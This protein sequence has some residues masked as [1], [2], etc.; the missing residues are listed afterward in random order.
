MMLNM[1]LKVDSQLLVPEVFPEPCR[2]S[3][4]VKKHFKMPDPQ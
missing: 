3:G 1:E 4:R 2:Q